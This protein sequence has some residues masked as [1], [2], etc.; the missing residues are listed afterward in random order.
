MSKGSKE[1][2]KNQPRVSAIQASALKT[3]NLTRRQRP[4]TFFYLPSEL[5]RDPLVSGVLERVTSLAI[6]SPVCQDLAAFW[7][8][9]VFRR[10]SLY[11]QYW[12][13]RSSQFPVHRRPKRLHALKFTLKTS[14]FPGCIDMHQKKDR[15]ISSLNFFLRRPHKRGTEEGIKRYRTAMVETSMT[16]VA[17]ARHAGLLNFHSSGGTFVPLSTL[18]DVYIE[19]ADEMIGFVHTEY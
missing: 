2:A 12:L 10:P 6:S 7:G 11:P 19:W 8:P 16:R 13:L 4:S 17:D 1:G 15:N 3:L 9:K 5:L 18:S 14:I